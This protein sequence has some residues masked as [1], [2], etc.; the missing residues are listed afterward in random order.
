MT[1]II[2]FAGQIWTKNGQ[3]KV[4]R[5][6]IHKWFSGKKEL[7]AYACAA[8]GAFGPNKM[9]SPRF[10]ASW[11]IHYGS[12]CSVFCVYSSFFVHF[13]LCIINAFFF[14]ASNDLTMEIQ[15]V[16]WW[17]KKWVIQRWMI[18]N[19]WNA[20]KRELNINEDEQLETCKRTF[21]LLT[22]TITN[23]LHTEKN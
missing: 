19:T 6:P 3:K 2:A 9:K 5:I 1:P 10:A 7:I 17:R 8:V 22:I 20:N 11:I 4:K 21:S 13:L 18:T 15:L 12:R 16:D 14:V 23:H